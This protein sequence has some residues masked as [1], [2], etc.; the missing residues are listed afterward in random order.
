MAI[1]TLLIHVED[2]FGTLERDNERLKKIIE[3]REK[4]IESLKAQKKKL[5]GELHNINHKFKSLINLL[6]IYK[7]IPQEELV[8]KI[9]TAKEIIFKTREIV[10]KTI[11]KE[12]KIID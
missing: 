4:E 5:T 8:N 1:K 3:N 11:L 6:S 10:I 12:E 7:N 9:K 2:E